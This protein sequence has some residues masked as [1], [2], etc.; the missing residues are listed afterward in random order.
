MLCAATYLSAKPPVFSDIVI[1]M[2]AQHLGT[3]I[4]Q[5]HLVLLAHLWATVTPPARGR[6]A[7]ACGAILSDWSLRMME[8]E[9][10]ASPVHLQHPTKERCGSRSMA[11]EVPV[12]LDTTNAEGAGSCQRIFDLQACLKPAAASAISHSVQTRQKSNIPVI[13]DLKQQKLPRAA[14]D[15]I[16][17][18]G[19]RTEHQMRPA[20][21]QENRGV[22]CYKCEQQTGQRDKKILLP[23]KDSPQNRLQSTSQTAAFCWFLWLWELVR[24]YT[25]FVKISL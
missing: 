5:Q 4:Q 14:L 3:S 22:N 25:L 21:T 2:P 23:S 8:R 20:D 7:P 10:W 1:C 11:H 16:R 19:T 17:S 24:L 6:A 13:T 15:H 12:S 9:G 18:L